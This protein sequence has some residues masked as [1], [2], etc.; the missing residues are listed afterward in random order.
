MPTAYSMDLR[1]R[2]AH[3]RLN[4]EPTADVAERFEV[5]T[6]WVRRLMQR[7]R[8]TG[9]I[10]VK[11]GKRGRKPKLDLLE[12][13][14]LVHE[15]PDATLAELRDTLGMDVALST[16][17]NTLRRLGITFKKSTPRRRAEPP[18]RR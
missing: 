9:S 4:G 8:E 15:R 3:A 17:F 2:V 6:A 11:N 16:I 7:R 18:R 1:E 5:S 12:L 14:E 13:Q 10:A